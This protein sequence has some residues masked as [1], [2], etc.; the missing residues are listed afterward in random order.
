MILLRI[1]SNE[2]A[3]VKEVA[4][5]LLQRKLAIDVNLKRNI[6]RWSWNGNSLENR[7][8][9]LLEAKTKALLFPKID[10]LIRE[11]IER[12]LPEIYSLPIVNM[13]WEQAEALTGEIEQ[14]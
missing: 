6:E 13:D 9:F 3:Q 8:I 7:K 5:F 10:K 4:S 11:K 1:V 12:N 14:V 2:E